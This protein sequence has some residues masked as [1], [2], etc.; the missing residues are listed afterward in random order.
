MNKTEFLQSICKTTG[1]FKRLSR[2]SPL[3]YPGAKTKAI[4]LITQYLPDSL[5]KK[6]VSPFIG[7]ASLEIAW[8]NNLDVE[9]VV[10]GDIFHP[11]VNFWNHILNE[12]GKLADELEKFQLGDHN[13]RIYKQIL[14]DWY[15]DPSKNKLTDLQ[16]AAHFYYNMQLSYGPMFLGWTSPGKPTTPE[17]YSRT[18]KR[19][20][21]FKCPKLKVESL[22]F[23]K[24][25]EKYPD[26]FVY[27]DPP[28]LL[29]YDSTVFKAIYPNQGGEHHKGFNHEL[30][31]DMMLDRKTGFIV[32]YNDCGTIRD[33][34]RDYEQFYPKWQY[35]FQQGE[36]RKKDQNGN[37]IKGAKDS[38]KTGNEILIVNSKYTPWTYTPPP[39]NPKPLKI[40][41]IKK[42]PILD[43][44]WFKILED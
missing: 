22:S 19:I 9:E 6:I 7:G 14:K 10:C 2:V 20:R 15:E 28:Y 43:S 26:H 42:E 16:A 39:A 13:Y 3:R 35:S 40:K 1:E 8:A 5:P 30:F 36:T 12:P 38:R 18:I 44:T 41:Q 34:F 24:T 33:W 4:G 27:A 17:E 11:L 21:E 25:L 37:S 31:R 32:S 29:G 23:E